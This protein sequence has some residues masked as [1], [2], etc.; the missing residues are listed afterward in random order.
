MTEAW[1]NT[2]TGELS[3]GEEATFILQQAVG[4]LAVPLAEI[5]TAPDF[6]YRKGDYAHVS[7]ADFSPEDGIAF[8]RQLVSMLGSSGLNV[9]M[10]FEHI[11]RAH[12][13]GLFPDMNFV[14]RRY[15]SLSNFRHLIG[16]E[17]PR[18]ASDYDSTPLQELFQKVFDEHKTHGAEGP[19]TIAELALF[20]NFGKLPSYDYLHHRFGGVKKLN[21]YLGYADV[22]SWDETDCI[23]YGALVLEENGTDSLTIPNIERLAAQKYGPYPQA[24]KKRVGTW[25]EFKQASLEEYWRQVEYTKRI[26]AA[27]ARHFESVRYDTSQVPTPDNRRA[28][29]AKYEVAKNCLSTQETDFLQQL[30]VL[31]T[32]EFIKVIQLKHRTKKLVDIETVALDLG[33]FDD[34]WP[35]VVPIRKPKLSESLLAAA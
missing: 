27:I 4:H 1:F 3:V 5:I 26:D 11:E 23:L 24:I 16:A 21:E 28:I 14:K 22:G 17:R 32:P 20:Y 13:L 2:G 29:W 12:I 33:V 18:P 19:I 34:L 25:D 8:G 7:A 6:P 35:R 10:R 31:P 15:G 9:P 30:S